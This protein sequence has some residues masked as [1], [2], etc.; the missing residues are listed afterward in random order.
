MTTGWMTPMS[1]WAYILEKLPLLRMGPLPNLYPTT[2]VGQNSVLPQGVAC[3]GQAS[4]SVDVTERA[5]PVY[6]P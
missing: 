4:L 6:L 5:R 2:M 3:S 1:L